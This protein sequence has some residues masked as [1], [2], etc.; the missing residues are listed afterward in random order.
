MAR[1]IRIQMAA[2]LILGLAG[3]TLKATPE[4]F[5]YRSS[6]KI[7][8]DGTVPLTHLHNFTWKPSTRDGLEAGSLHLAPDVAQSLRD[9]I[10]GNLASCYRWQSSGTAD[11]WVSYRLRPP[12]ATEKTPNAGPRLRINV[13]L[14]GTDQPA[15]TSEIEVP[16]DFAKHGQPMKAIVHDLLIEFPDGNPRQ[17]R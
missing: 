10:V 6:I 9:A 16:P 12:A 17:C 14:H 13:G 3:C 7:F 8:R 4:P 2:L 11:F 5:Q 1:T 15:W